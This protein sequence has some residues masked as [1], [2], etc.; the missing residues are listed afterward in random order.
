MAAGALKDITG[1]TC[2]EMEDETFLFAP[3]E[4]RYARLKVRLAG[5]GGEWGTELPIFFD[6]FQVRVVV[7]KLGNSRTL[8]CAKFVFFEI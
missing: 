7:S 5:G 4:A 2:A 6:K 1:L 3:T 8:Q